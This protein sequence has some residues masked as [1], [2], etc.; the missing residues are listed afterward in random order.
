MIVQEISKAYESFFH[1]VLSLFFYS[2]YVLYSLSV[3]CCNVRCI[4]LSKI[5]IALS[6]Y[7][8][9]GLSGTLICHLSW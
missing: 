1:F 7:G 3:Q 4:I 8:L 6:F 9:K 5:G 2:D